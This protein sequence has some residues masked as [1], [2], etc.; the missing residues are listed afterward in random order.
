MNKQLFIGSTPFVPAGFS[1]TV[2]IR[3]CS[4]EEIR[5]MIADTV[6]TVQSYCGHEGSARFLN[7]PMNRG[8]VPAP[9]AGDTQHWV[10]IRPTRRPQPGEELDPTKDSDFVGW[11]MLIEPSSVEEDD[12]YWFRRYAGD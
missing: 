5:K 12:W 8:Q 3:H 2:Q 10:G 4:V 11:E 1:G 6:S 9:E 7:V